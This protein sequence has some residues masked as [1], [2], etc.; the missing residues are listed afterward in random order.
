MNKNIVVSSED[1]RPGCAACCIAVSISSMIPDMPN[2]K[3]AGER[4]IQLDEK[5]LCRLF[6]K[7]G[8]PDVC[9]GLK[10]SLEM[11]GKSNAEAFAYLENLERETNS[12]H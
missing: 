8:R 6:G 3:K 11:C 5:N 4:C 9:S 12:K 1:C 7:A 2:G 10:P